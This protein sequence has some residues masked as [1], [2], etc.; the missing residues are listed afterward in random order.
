M[1]NL[2]DITFVIGLIV[3]FKR[4]GQLRIRIAA[5]FGIP[6]V[7]RNIGKD[8][9]RKDLRPYKRKHQVLKSLFPFQA[10]R[11]DHSPKLFKSDK[12]RYFMNKSDK[13][14]VFIEIGI[15]RDPVDSIWL[16][17]VIS[18]PGFSFIDDAQVN[19][20]DLDQVKD[21]GHGMIW[22]IFF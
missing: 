16:P 20:I 4:Y 1:G 11:F 8:F 2:E 9:R 7:S 13:E 5:R 19:A 21:R 10:M 6:E 3:F 14:P 18:V 15:N 12:M 22:Y 17:P